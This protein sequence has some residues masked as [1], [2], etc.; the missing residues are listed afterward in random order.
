MIRK[1]CIVTLILLILAIAASTVLGNGGKPPSS[2]SLLHMPE[3]MSTAF[4]SPVGPP[5]YL[6]S[7]WLSISELTMEYFVVDVGDDPGYV[8]Y[9]LW[10]DV[11]EPGVLLCRDMTQVFTDTYF[12]G[13]MTIY[14]DDIPGQDMVQGC[15]VS[16]FW[17][18]EPTQSWYACGFIDHWWI[19]YEAYLP[20][21]LRNH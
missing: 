3:S 18:C 11:C 13:E 12:T 6:D 2:E 19:P 17:G 8:G 20:L 14:W 10:V 9:S 5:S 1:L 7:Y 4:R 21:V 16:W 15:Y